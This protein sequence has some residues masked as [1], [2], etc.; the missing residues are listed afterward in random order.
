MQLH[1]HPASAEN[2]ILL[3]VSAFR[4]QCGALVA[5]FNHH[6]C[7]LEMFGHQGCGKQELKFMNDRICGCRNNIDVL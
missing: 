4:Q 7:D 3:Y 1:T 6:G 5:M 2:R